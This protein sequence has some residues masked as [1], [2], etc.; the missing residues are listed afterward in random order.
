MWRE[1]WRQNRKILAQ[2]EQKFLQFNSFIFKKSFWQWKSQLKVLNTQFTYL[3]YSFIE[4]SRKQRD[5]IFL[6]LWVPIKLPTQELKKQ[7]RMR[8]QG[9][10]YAGFAPCG[11]VLLVLT[12]DHELYRTESCVSPNFWTRIMELQMTF[13]FTWEMLMKIQKIAGD[14]IQMFIRFSSPMCMFL[15]HLTRVNYNNSNRLMKLLLKKMQN[16]T[17]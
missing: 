5:V 4:C 17:C 15:E 7:R 10:W 9:N 6:I 3:S 12:N 13:L 2:D 14:P 11:D 1:M 16:F 8:R